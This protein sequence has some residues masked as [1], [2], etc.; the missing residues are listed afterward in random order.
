MYHPLAHAKQKCTLDVTRPSCVLDF[1]CVLH[2]TL[3]RKLGIIEG[4][5]F[6]LTLIAAYHFPV[7][8]TCA[9]YH[10]HYSDVAKK[11]TKRTKSSG[12]VCLTFFHKLWTK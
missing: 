9:K 12:T 4:V 5:L 11:N 8:S 2:V 6:H 7:L 1:A 3:L 10:T